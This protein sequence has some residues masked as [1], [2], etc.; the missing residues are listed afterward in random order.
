[1]VT[2][3]GWPET[4][5]LFGPGLEIDGR[6]YACEEFAVTASF[7]FQSIYDAGTKTENATSYVLNYEGAMFPSVK[8]LGPGLPTEGRWYPTTESAEQASALF[9][10]IFDAGRLAVT[11]ETIPQTRCEV[12]PYTRRVIDEQ[13][14]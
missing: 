13:Q 3:T 11:R 2:D 6:E 12:D 9:Q 8:L 14:P 4:A 1:M 10:R 5:K 7:L